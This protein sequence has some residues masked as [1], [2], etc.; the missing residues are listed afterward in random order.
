[1]LR[2]MKSLENKDISLT[3]SMIPLGSC[4]MKLNPT[5]AMLALSL[6]K[7]SQ[8]HPFISSTSTIGYQDILKE[9]ESFLKSGG[10]NIPRDRQ[11]NLE[12]YVEMGDMYDYNT[13]V[14]EM[15]NKKIAIPISLKKAQKADPP[16][17]NI[18]NK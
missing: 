5:S 8:I 13:Y 2:Y 7:A 16:S 15:F 14:D 9:L 3:H 4:T 17:P 18:Q 1:M 6:E 12:L 11:K 10:R